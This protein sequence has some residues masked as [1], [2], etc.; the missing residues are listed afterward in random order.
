MDLSYNS[1]TYPIELVN[2]NYNHYIVNNKLNSEFYQYYLKN[3]LNIPIEKNEKNF[4][5]I[6]NIIDHDVNLINLTPDQELIIK[7]NTYEIINLCNSSKNKNKNDNDHDI[8]H[9]NSISNNNDYDNLEPIVSNRED[10]NDSDS[11]NDFIKLEL[12]EL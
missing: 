9:T 12:S 8:I 4:N 5:Y 11:S 1:E 2:E 10:T 7:E 6:V 3:V